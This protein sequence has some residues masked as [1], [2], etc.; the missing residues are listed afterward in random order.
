MLKD[1]APLPDSHLWRAPRRV[2][3]N[4]N[5]RRYRLG[6][7]VPESEVATPHEA[8]IAA[9]NSLVQSAG[10]RAA[11]AAW[12][13]AA[14]EDYWTRIADGRWIEANRLSRFSP[15]D[16][17]AGRLQNDISLARVK[18]L[19]GEDRV[20]S[21]TQ[22]NEYGIC[23]FRFYARRM[24]HLEKLE[25]PEEGLNPRHLGTLYHEVLEATYKR[26][27]EQGGKISADNLDGA[28]AVLHEE[29][30]RLLPNA[31]RRIGFRR[32]ALWTQEQNV[33]LRRLE[34][35][36]RADFGESNPV[37]K[38]FGDEAR[39]P[40]RL[41]APFGGDFRLQLG[42]NSI[43]VRGK[44]DRIDRQGDRLI[45]MDYKTGSTPIQSQEISD[46]RNFQMMLYL[47]AAEAM[48]MVAHETGELPSQVAGGIFIHLSSITGSGDLRFDADGLEVIKAGEAHLARY[49]ERGRT[50][51]FA[52]HSNK[53]ENGRCA[54]YCDYHQFCRTAIINRR[55]SDTL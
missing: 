2:L 21:A 9:A 37:K 55:K 48:I 4:A 10:K 6:D 53:V 1:G 5:L 29:A 12:L 22:L 35:F 36:V 24:L 54:H 32:S 33:I 23:P 30:D 15:Y 20:W 43:R 38:A 39:T 26:I 19:L 7:V 17:Y 28:L 16:A 11:L 14:H 41:E 47:R 49:I 45:V 52:V 34:N 27:A 8:A 3:P 44:I 46:G 18:M 40:Y 42:D 13:N 50:G 51:D 31:P 25:E